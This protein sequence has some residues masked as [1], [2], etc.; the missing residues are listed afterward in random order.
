MTMDTAAT[1][2]PASPAE[3]IRADIRAGRHTTVTTG[4]AP[5]YLQ[6]NL[7]ILPADWAD[8]FA[9]FCA[10]NAKACPL[11]AQSAVG[12]PTLPTLG[13][14]INVC[15]DLPRY[16]VFHDGG[17]TSEETVASRGTWTIECIACGHKDAT[18]TGEKEDNS[19]RQVDP[20]SDQEFI[21]CPKCKKYSMVNED[22]LKMR[23]SML[24]G[25]S[26]V[27]SMTIECVACGHKITDWTGE[28]ERNSDYQVDPQSR[29]EFV[30]CPKCKKYGMV[31]EGWVDKFKN[32]PGMSNGKSGRFSIIV[33]IVAAIAIAFVIYWVISDDQDSRQAPA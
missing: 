17:Q 22:W 16:R 6:A 7:V 3:I 9:V 8:E 23:P 24:N 31:Y 26:G 21:K 20:K 14:D 12:D 32:R 10:A 25:K 13:R 18:W 5:G 2:T 29:Q 15:T 4:L 30:K 11:I 33:E 1:L 19:E 28:K 27:F